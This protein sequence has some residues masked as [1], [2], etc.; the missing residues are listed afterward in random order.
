MSKQSRRVRIKYILLHLASFIL[1][2]LIPIYILSTS[3]GVL[4]NLVKYSWV[5]LF[6]NEVSTT[7]SIA[8]SLISNP[9]ESSANGTSPTKRMNLFSMYIFFCYTVSLIHFCTFV[10]LSALFKTL[11]AL[12]YAILIAFISYFGLCDIYKSI[13]EVSKFRI[14][15]C[16]FFKANF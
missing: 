15:F 2:S 13:D 6:S 1:L 9:V 16:L 8:T 4:C 7:T 5:S 10:Q 11:L 3:M 12:V 14:C